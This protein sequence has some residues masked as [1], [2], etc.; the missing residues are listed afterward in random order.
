MVEPSKA[1]TTARGHLLVAFLDEIAA[2]L[3]PH[4]RVVLASASRRTAARQTLVLRRR[5]SSSVRSNND[6]AIVHLHRWLVREYKN[7]AGASRTLHKGLGSKRQRN[8]VVLSAAQFRVVMR[9]LVLV[10]SGVRASCLVDCCALEP[11]LV[12]LLL[13][14]LT[15]GD[16]NKK[17]RGGWD[18]L[19]CFDQV[20]TVILEGNVFFVNAARFLKA[21]SIDLASSLNNLLGVNVSA[22]LEEPEVLF[23]N[24]KQ[25]YAIRIEELCEAIETI[26]DRLCDLVLIGTPGHRVL[27]LDVP[28]AVSTTA[29]AG[30]LLCYPAIYDLYP[31][32]SRALVFLLLSLTQLFSIFSGSDG[33]SEGSDIPLASELSFPVSSIAAVQTALQEFSIPQS[34]VQLKP[35]VCQRVQ[36]SLALIKASCKVA[37]KNAFEARCW[38]TCLQPRKLEAEVES[39][40]MKASRRFVTPRGIRVN[41]HVR[42]VL[43]H[44]VDCIQ[45]QTHITQRNAYNAKIHPHQDDDCCV[46]GGILQTARQKERMEHFDVE[47]NKLGLGIMLLVHQ[48][49]HPVLRHDLHHRKQQCKRR[50]SETGELIE[51]KCVHWVDIRVSRKCFPHTTLSATAMTMHAQGADRVTV[52]GTGNP[53]QHANP[54]DHR[55]DA[56]ALISETDII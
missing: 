5:F 18:A 43:H 49:A 26:C 7:T 13:D 19:G 14:A 21:K 4:E 56:T 48:I 37:L 17:T 38:D 44:L 39:K 16:N 54:N 47:N 11:A 30:I 23:P 55:I 36:P 9:D 29:L 24:A 27:E 34:V 28:F 42:F 46:R 22:H 41:A 10:A 3:P 51:A 12:A 33:N 8:A 40:V 35:T 20:Y 15:S 6:T 31:F 45:N 32:L 1:P 50:L 52:K 53:I 25:D 2:Y